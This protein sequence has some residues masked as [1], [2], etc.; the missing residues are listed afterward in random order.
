MLTMMTMTIE[1]L[2]EMY[3]EVRE[4]FA[5]GIERVRWIAV[6]N[7]VHEFIDDSEDDCK[8]CRDLAFDRDLDN[9]VLGV[10]KDLNRLDEY[11][12]T[13]AL[14]SRWAYLDANCT[15]DDPCIECRRE[16]QRQGP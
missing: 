6:L 7:E 2:N 15:L 4:L 3:R 12:R 1:R 9:Q 13:S 14:V 11:K 5:P 8:E 16:M 10:Y